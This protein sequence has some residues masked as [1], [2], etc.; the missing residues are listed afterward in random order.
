MG[1]AKRKQSATQRL[2]AEFPNCCFC[3]GLRLTNTR[4]HMPP[5]SL[6]DRSHRPDGL[7]M[8]AC[9]EC[10][11]GTSTA[12][13]AVA[14]LSRW[15]Y[16]SSG[17]QQLDHAKL[18]KRARIQAPELIAEWLAIDAGEKQKA[19]QH[20]LNHGVQV[21]DD[22]GIAT[23]GPLSVGQLNL[24]AHKVVLALYFTHFGRALSNIGRMCAFWRTKE[25][26][27][28]SGI[29]K[30]FF[31]LLPGYGTIAQG[32]WN[33]SKTFEYRHAENIGEGLFGCLA[34]FRQGFFAC[35]FTVDDAGRLPE[36]QLREW[37]RPDELLTIPQLHRKKL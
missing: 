21:P 15:D 30:I 24:F 26:F 4:E 8:P 11:K 29:P 22:A 37:F 25:D 5:T 16:D 35:G 12:D 20:L 10:N 3:G 33:E 9:D 23:L 36:T 32:Q 18:V 7:I 19:R 31:D 17:Q 6:F 2:I 1:E 34:R 28:R 27:A 14:L 13:L